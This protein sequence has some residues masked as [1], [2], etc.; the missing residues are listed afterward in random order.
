MSEEAN[1]TCTPHA[2]I[3]KSGRG[4]DCKDLSSWAPHKAC[5]RMT[6]HPGLA[7]LG[8]HFT[9]AGHPHGDQKS[10][11]NKGTP[12]GPPGLEQLWT[13]S[14]KTTRQP[15]A[16]SSP[17][18]FQPRPCQERLLTVLMETLAPQASWSPTA[19]GRSRPPQRQLFLGA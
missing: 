13:P 14:L 19:A 8:T 1:G 6:G 16:Y 5:R 15:H 11:S 17:L 18:L 7:L 10:C 12:R 4:V 2:F 3:F 9:G